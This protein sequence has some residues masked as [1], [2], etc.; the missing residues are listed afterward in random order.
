MLTS[1][2]ITL[3]K[4]IRSML[5]A[6][7]GIG[8]QGQ[9]CTDKERSYMNSSCPQIFIIK[10]MYLYYY[11][12]IIVINNNIDLDLN[13]IHILLSLEVNGHRIIVR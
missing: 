2:L 3:N 7:N 11:Y 8:S 5:C 6:C 13:Y 4:N 1:G 9:E 12:I 10:L